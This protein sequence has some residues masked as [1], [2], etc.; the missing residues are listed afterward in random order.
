MVQH[1]CTFASEHGRHISRRSDNVPECVMLNSL[2]QSFPCPRRQGSTSSAAKRFDCM[3]KPPDHA[4]GYLQADE[5]ADHQTCLH[6]HVLG[7]DLHAAACVASQNTRLQNASPLA[8]QHGGQR[9][10]REAQPPAHANKSTPELHCHNAC[11]DV[12]VRI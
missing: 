10:F 1:Q 9:P 4:D 12:Q 5:S 6:A 3:F 11:N 2:V 8:T 7:L